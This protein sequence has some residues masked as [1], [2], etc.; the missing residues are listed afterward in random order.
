MLVAVVR[1]LS[2]HLL[3]FF[4]PVDFL[5]CLP[6]VAAPR[7]AFRARKGNEGLDDAGGFGEGEVHAGP[8][9][10]RQQPV[11][12]VRLRGGREVWDQPHHSAGVSAD[13]RPG[14]ASP[15]QRQHGLPGGTARQN[16]VL[17]LLLLLLLLLLL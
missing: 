12:G 16:P 11:P 3:D 10:P 1:P 15:D 2:S 13:F 17:S 9:L 14:F 6:C 8:G 4:I 5:P 7:T